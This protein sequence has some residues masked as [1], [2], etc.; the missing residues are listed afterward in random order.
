MKRT[1]LALAVL[2][3]VI[4][5]HAPVGAQEYDP[6]L[7][8]TESN[9]MTETLAYALENARTGEE[10]S[11]VNPDTG[12]SGVIVPL[13]TY[14]NDAGLD[15]REYIQ[16]IVIDGQEAQAYGTACRQPDGTWLIVN[17]EEAAAPPPE[18]QTSHIYLYRDPASYHYPWVYYDPFF[19]PHQI[20]FSFVFVHH[21]GHFSHEH[22]HEGR[23]YPRGEHPRS[24]ERHSFGAHRVADGREIPSRFHADGNPGGRHDSDRR[25][26][27]S[28]RGDDPRRHDPDPRRAVTVYRGNPGR[29][30][31]DHSATVRGDT[32]ARRGLDR[33]RAGSVRGD[34]PRRHD[35]DPRHAGT[36]YRGN[37][38]RRVPDHSAIVRGNIPARRDL[39]RRRS[40]ALRGA[41]P[42]TAHPGFRGSAGRSGGEQVRGNRG[43]AGGRYNPGQPSFN[44]R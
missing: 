5:S 15:C 43:G 33:H 39:D 14:V 2:G 7:D 36:V 19:Y 1:T 38:G 23:H 20:F 37:P 12:H 31:S 4:F 3:W 44:R 6:M 8:D 26:A 25:R 18:D 35:P 17:D 27:G 40:G 16:T 34:N 11:W 9:A 32:P 29:H 41:P 42:R 30:V 28:G 21:A 22:F 10:S 13:A 24:R